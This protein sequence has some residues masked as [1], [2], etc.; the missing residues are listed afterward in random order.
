[1]CV[2]DRCNGGGEASTHAASVD[3]AMR[4]RIAALSDANALRREFVFGPPSCLR[5]ALRS[6]LAD[7]RDEPLLYLLLN[8]LLTTAPAAVAVYSLTAAVSRPWAH[9]IGAAYLA[10]NYATFLQ[11][12]LLGLH[13]AAHRPLFKPAWRALDG[14]M[15]YLVAP[16]FGIPAGMY[17]LHHCVMHHVVRAQALK[18]LGSREALSPMQ[19]VARAQGRFLLVRCM[20]RVAQ[21]ARHPPLDRAPPRFCRPIDWVPYSFLTGSPPNPADPWIGAP[22]TSRGGSVFA[23]SAAGL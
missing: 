21:C 15:P 2:A 23:R 18:V 16:L 8:I 11:R 13:C 3:P 9:A 12:F 20:Q 17:Q 22:I 6:A 19:H 1:M 4:A 14:V 10:A 5:H 7:P